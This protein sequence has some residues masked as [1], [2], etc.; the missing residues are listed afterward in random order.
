MLD[1][2]VRFSKKPTLR[3]RGACRRLRGCSWSQH[4]RGEGE[5][6]VRDWAKGGA[7]L[8]RPHNRDPSGP[9]GELQ[10]LLGARRWSLY[11]AKANRSWDEA[12]PGRRGG[13]QLSGSAAKRC[14]VAALPAARGLGASCPRRTWAAPRSTHCRRHVSVMVL[15]LIY[16][17][18]QCSRPGLNGIYFHLWW[19]QYK[20]TVCQ[21]CKIFIDKEPRKAYG[22]TMG[23]IFEWSLFRSLLFSDLSHFPHY[24][25]L[26]YGNDPYG[27]A[28]S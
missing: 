24:Y 21:S 4:C 27:S 20:C 6:G 15:D 3:G 18:N 26:P 14:L 22:K 25:L 28:S 7:G 1:F 9:T 5:G 23:V 12:A 8:W 16:Q 17:T 2:Q 13:C 10:G 11:V 19:K